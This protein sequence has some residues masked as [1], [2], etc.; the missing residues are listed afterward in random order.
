MVEGLVAWIVLLEEGELLPKTQGLDQ[1]I[2]WVEKEQLQEDGTGTGILVMSSPTAGELMMLQRLVHAEPRLNQK[3]CSQEG[4]ACKGTAAG[5][6][7]S[8]IEEGGIQYV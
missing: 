2:L 7:H 1:H 6:T 4:F 3:N 8:P 5:V